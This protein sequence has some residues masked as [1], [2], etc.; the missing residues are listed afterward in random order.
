MCWNLVTFKIDLLYREVFK[1][2][3]MPVAGEKIIE[4]KNPA[5]SFKKN[6]RSDCF[7]WWA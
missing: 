5:I 7:I 3:G 6:S 1:L 2:G 4:Y